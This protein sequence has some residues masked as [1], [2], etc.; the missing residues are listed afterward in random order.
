VVVALFATALFGVLVAIID[1]E[2][3]L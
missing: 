3:S 2:L 1:G